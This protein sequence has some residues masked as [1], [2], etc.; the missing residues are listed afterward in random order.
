MRLQEYQSKSLFSRHGIPVPRGQVVSSAEEARA[1]AEALGGAVAVKAQVLIG[2]RGKAGGIR[3]AHDRDEA[4]TVAMGILGMEIRGCRVREVLV[5][6]AVDISQ[7]I[8]LGLVIDRSLHRVVMMASAEGGVEIEQV[9]RDNPEAIV[10]VIID[11]LHGL[12]DAQTPELAQAIGLPE[13]THTAFDQ[14]A[15]GLYE[16]FESSDAV[17]AEINPL[18]ITGEGKLLALDGKMDLDDNALFRHPDLAEMREMSEETPAERE[19]REAGLSY[20]Q[21]DGDIGCVVNG[22]GLAMAT[23]DVIKHFGGAPSNFLDVGGGATAD[24][25]A[26]A[27]GIILATPG[28]KAVLVN[29]FGGITL[30]DEVAR[31]IVSALDASEVRVPMVARIEGTN[32][33]EGQEILRNSGYALTSAGTLSEAAETVVAMVGEASQA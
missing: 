8:Y 23:M 5:E 3:L 14:I 12:T 4:E 24:R 29:I 21:L 17:L 32:E 13:S 25:V 22:A 1:A 18:V 28:L 27:V 20:V 7:E 10:R 19:A 26:K 11:P 33:A 31:G 30:C 2:G 6:A 9:A 16:A 15:R